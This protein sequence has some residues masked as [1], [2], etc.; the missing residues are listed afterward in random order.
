MDRAAFCIMRYDVTCPTCGLTS[1]IQKA[2]NAPIPICPDCGSTR[3]RL[4]GVPIVH[5]DA[6]GFHATD[7]RLERQIGS[8]RAAR[9]RAQRDD[10]EARAKRGQLTPYERALEA[11]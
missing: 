8:E 4:Y 9:F 1:E 7:S 3:V 11:G 5:F 6:P 10:A 2:M